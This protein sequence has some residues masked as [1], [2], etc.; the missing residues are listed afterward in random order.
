MLSASV[1][2]SICL[3]VSLSLCLSVWWDLYCVRK[4]KWNRLIF[5]TQCI[6]C[7]CSVLAVPLLPAR[8]QWSDQLSLWLTRR[9]GILYWNVYV[10]SSWDTVGQHWKTFSVHRI[11]ACSAWQCFIWTYFWLWQWHCSVTLYI[12]T[13]CPEKK[14]PK[15]FW[16][17][18]R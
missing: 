2:L 16:E 15:C 6:A 4:Q 1:C 9:C 7:W 14:R 5:T 12:Y 10:W 13:V 8:T 18:L 17:Y 11:D 3:S